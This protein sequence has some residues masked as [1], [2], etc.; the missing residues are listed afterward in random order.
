MF[1]L[2]LYDYLLSKMMELDQ[3]EKVRA[4]ETFLQPKLGVEARYTK[5]MEGGATLVEGWEGLGPP[6]PETPRIYLLVSTKL[7]ETPGFHGTSLENQRT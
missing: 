3:T 1:L 7:M 5:Q 6:C 4:R 2:L